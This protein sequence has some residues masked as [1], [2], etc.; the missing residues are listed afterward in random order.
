MISPHLKK[1]LALLVCLVPGLDMLPLHA[2][3]PSGGSDKAA[4]CVA[5]RPVW[6]INPA[7]FESNHERYGRCIS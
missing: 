7:D 5:G 2:Q 3:A 6:V 4:V 1:L